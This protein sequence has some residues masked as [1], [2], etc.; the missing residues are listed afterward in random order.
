MI[1]QNLDQLAVCCVCFFPEGYQSYKRNIT[2]T[3]K[4]NLWFLSCVS[5]LCVHTTGLDGSL[6]FLHHA[7]STVQPSQM[8]DVVLACKE[9]LELL[10]WQL[11]MQ[12]TVRGRAVFCVV[13]CHS[14]SVQGTLGPWAASG[15]ACARVCVCAQFLMCHVCTNIPCG[16]HTH[17]SGL[18]LLVWGMLSFSSQ[19]ALQQHGFLLFH[20]YL[21]D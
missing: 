1:W 20:M 2:V 17:H 7:G 6:V 14:F 3:F 10:G 8:M 5:A 16:S 15:I 4:Q 12:V 13:T 19:P 18:M 11:L 9:V 21:E